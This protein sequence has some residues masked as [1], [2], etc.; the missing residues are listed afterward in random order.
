MAM[1]TPASRRGAPRASRTGFAIARARCRYDMMY[2]RVKQMHTAMTS[3]MMVLLRDCRRLMASI[4]LFTIGNLAAQ[5]RAP[6]RVTLAK[7]GRRG[8]RPWS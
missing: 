7:N 4:M 8:V 5:A 1:V 2:H 3:A 6:C